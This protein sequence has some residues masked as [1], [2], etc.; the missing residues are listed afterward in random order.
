MH[1]RAGI[2]KVAP[3][4][5]ARIIVA[6]EATASDIKLLGTSFQKPARTAFW[7]EARKGFGI[8]CCVHT[9]GRGGRIEAPIFKTFSTKKFHR[10]TR[11]LL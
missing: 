8:H 2:W 6:R 9:I 3:N 7:D 4:S 10:S 1:R 11:D 5:F